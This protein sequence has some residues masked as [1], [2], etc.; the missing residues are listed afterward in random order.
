LPCAGSK[1]HGND[2]FNQIQILHR[3]TPKLLNGFKNTKIL[4][5]ATYVD[6]CL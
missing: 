3:T 4:H 2:L 6:Y 1:M 5:R